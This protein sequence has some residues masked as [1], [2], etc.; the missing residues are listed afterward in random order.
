MPGPSKPAGAEAPRSGARGLEWFKPRPP[1][2]T[3]YRATWA[4]IIGIDAYPGGSSGLPRLEHALNDAHVFR[5]TLEKE[6]GYSR[7]RIAFLADKSASRK[8]I[9]AALET[10]LPSRNIQEHDAVLVFFAGHG[11]RDGYLAAADSEGNTL[12]SSGLSVAWL[13]DRLG[14]L[15]C[16]H[17]LILLDSCYSGKLFLK[18][19]SVARPSTAESAPHGR[20]QGAGRSRSDSGDPGGDTRLGAGGSDTLSYYLSRP[21]FCGMSAG[22]E[23]PVAD[24]LGENRHSAFTAALLRVL[25]E[26]ANSPRKDHVFTFREMASQVEAYTRTTPGTRQIPDSGRLAPGD[27]D[28]LFFPSVARATPR[29]VQELAKELLAQA[30]SISRRNLERLAHGQS[31]RE[32]LLTLEAQRSI[33]DIYLSLSTRAELPSTEVYQHVLD[34]KGAVLV[35][36]RR[37]TE[38][39]R[40][41][42]LAPFFTKLQAATA[43][44]ASHFHGPRDGEWG[45]RLVELI[46]GREQRERDL[47]RRL[48]ALTKG[49]GFAPPTVARVQAAL[50]GDTVLVDFVDYTSFASAVDSARGG[51]GERRLAA[52]I[53]HRCGDVARID[54]GRI[55]PITRHVS[56]W[57]A[58]Y[59]AGK[60]PTKDSLDPA[61]ELRR[62]VWAP[63][64]EK[65]GGAKVILLAP[66]GDLTG[67]PFAALPGSK[68]G[69]F[70]LEEYTFVTIPVP[71][72]LPDLLADPG[73]PPQR[74]A[75]LLLVGDVDFGQPETTFK[76]LPSTRAEVISIKDSFEQRFPQAQVQLLRKAQASKQAFLAEVGTHNHVHLATHGFF[77][78]EKVES[79]FQAAACSADLHAG[80]RL[81]KDVGGE[82]PG[83]LSGVV[84]AGA[85]DADA[86]KRAASLLTALEASELD[87]R[88]VELVVLSACDTGRGRVAGG[89]GVLGLQ[90]AFQV[91]GARGVVA[92]LWQVNDRA[93]Q[94][95]MVR[96]YD[97]LW[98]PGRPPSKLEA[99][100]QAQ[101]WMLRE[102]VRDGVVAR[103]LVPLDELEGSGEG[104]RVPPYYWAAF[105]LSGDWR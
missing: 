36:Q 82:L 79:V 31:E 93:T 32:Q 19:D 22:R 86:Q 50:P 9:R 53:V 63:L 46:D 5:D 29:E 90:R 12:A 48:A 23:T 91:A 81:Q 40:H 3:S 77:A 65:L 70:L 21:A 96:F 28:F 43:R 67:L 72:L 11:T 75:A 52:F 98:R 89:E 100:R 51:E 7:D 18:E 69:S 94:E 61:V 34:W 68:R 4:V 2:P 20:P 78:D 105:V 56:A 27:G 26:R 95:L 102:G 30:A 85:N 73:P 15:P 62:L 103:D 76:R 59:G 10:W 16:R 39:R 88:G 66:D 55:E 71:Q 42:E 104:A 92:S 24:G 57:R 99:L 80:L 38:A 25:R 35:R 83:L 74:P 54:L 60:E 1:Q 44:L 87:L 13:R 6:F 14:A 64:E 45:P 41:P 47:T 49:Q 58:S 17:K 8:A 101:L 33:L 84:F 97:N 37:L